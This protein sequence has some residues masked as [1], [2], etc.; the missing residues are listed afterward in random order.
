[1]SWPAST[2]G[3]PFT[4]ATVQAIKL[5][6]QVQRRQTRI[7]GGSGIDIEDAPWQVRLQLGQY[8]CG[9]TLID[10]LWVLTA[11]H[12]AEDMEPSDVT[13]WDG[14]TYDSDMTMGNGIDVADVIVHPA[15][16][17][18][19]NLNDVA[20][21]RLAEPATAGTPI[22]LFE[23]R[24]GP[25]A[26]TPAFISGWG[27][28]TSGGNS[29]DRLQG[30]TIEVRTSPS[31]GCGDYGSDYDN[32]VM[33]CAGDDAGSKDTCQGD[34]GGPLIVPVGSGWEL[35]GVTS[36]GY[37]CASPGYPGI[38]ARVSTYVPW[39]YRTM[40]WDTVATVSCTSACTSARVTGLDPSAEY[41][42]RVALSNAAGRG[43]WS[44]PSARTA[45]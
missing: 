7:V 44:T 8:A 42:F 34:S 24:S 23:D 33:L 11:A 15:W 26:G 6:D 13:V 2:S 12:C 28:L 16:E 5:P 37:G 43:S 9:G 30:T 41:V 17:S 40:S 20:L 19:D 35:A 31:G 38:Y 27:T 39:I 29:P 36:W 14:R 10:E 45:I 4:G 18:K 22:R 25:A 1:V 32:T 3:G 21:L